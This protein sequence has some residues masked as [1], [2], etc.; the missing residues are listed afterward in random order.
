MIDAYAAL[1]EKLNALPDEA[2]RFKAWFED[3]WHPNGAGHAL[4]ADLS[5]DALRTYF[6]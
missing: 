1:S 4:Y 5:Y 2:A 3:N 6:D